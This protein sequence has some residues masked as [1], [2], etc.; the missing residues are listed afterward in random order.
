MSDEI[1]EGGNYA[2]GCAVW[3]LHYSKGVWLTFFAL[4]GL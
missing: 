1:K 3:C 2:E 4:Q